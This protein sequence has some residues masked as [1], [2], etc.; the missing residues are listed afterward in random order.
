MANAISMYQIQQNCEGCI[1]CPVFA[2][3]IISGN[4]LNRSDLFIATISV[5]LLQNVPHI[6]TLLCWSWLFITSELKL[7][8]ISGPLF[9][10]LFDEIV[11]ENV[12]GYISTLT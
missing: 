12:L 6:E 10:C 1:C 4:M 8:C 5:Q 11:L 2:H 7:R 3:L 9:F